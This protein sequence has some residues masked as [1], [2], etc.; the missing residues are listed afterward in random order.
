MD[1]NIAKTN[2]IGLSRDALAAS[3]NS[4]NAERPMNAKA[5][6]WLAVMVVSRA[7]GYSRWPMVG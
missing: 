3:S 1:T 2:L 5:A 4:G 7:C 6:A